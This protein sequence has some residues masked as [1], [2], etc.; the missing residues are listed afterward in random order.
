MKAF[1][2]HFYFMFAQWPSIV[3]EWKFVDF[4]QCS[5]AILRTT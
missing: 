5:A 2:R 4:H 1:G 3:E